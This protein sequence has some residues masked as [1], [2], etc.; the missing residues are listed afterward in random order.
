MN[1]IIVDL[2][3]TITIDK[4]DLDY[5]SKPA[6]RNVIEAIKNCKKNYG[7]TIFTARNMRTYKG[8]LDKI[9]Q[10]TKPI[11]LKW[12]KDNNVIFDEAIFGKPFCGKEGFYVDDKNLSI[13]EFCFKFSGPFRDTK[14]DIVI[15][16]YNEE[17]NIIDVY[18]EHKRLERLFNVGNYIFVNNGSTDNSATK[19]EY[20]KSIED[21]ILVLNVEK[22]IGY[23][24]GIKCGLEKCSSEFV[25]INHSDRQFNAYSYF[26]THLDEIIKIQSKESIFS[27][28]TGRKLKDFIQTFI[29]HTL[30][31]AISLKK[32]RDFNGQPKL[33]K[34]ELLGNISTLPNNYTLDL[35]IFKRVKPKH[36]YS[37]IEKK[38]LKGKSSWSKNIISKLL[39]F[40]SYVKQSLSS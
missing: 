12:L 24:N 35:E 32:I 1:K 7:V 22:N 11:A 10:N 29:L 21:K 15:P 16:F 27:I 33:V 17:D 18:Y 37:I 39:I 38:R 8:D 40:I 25:L 20:L 23:G 30:I 2:D 36:F 14:I 13:E 5:P 9:N 31:S 6:N 28:R 3:N 19:F 4:K 34:K 26:L